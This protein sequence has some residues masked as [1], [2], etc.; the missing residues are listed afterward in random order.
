VEVLNCMDC[1]LVLLRVVDSWLLAPFGLR[2]NLR[3]ASAFRVFQLG[4]AVRAVQLHD[5][6]RELWL[7]ISAV[8]ETMWTLFWVGIMVIGVIYVCGILVSMAVLDKTQE[9]FNLERAEWD[10]NEYWGS[11][12]RSSYSLFQVVT[13][14]KWSDSLVWPLVE[15]NPELM[16]VF[17]AFFTVASLSL[18][19]S[20]VGVVVESTLA[21]ARA[22]ADREQKEKER[23]DAQVLESMKQI[24]H[25]ADT[26][27]SGQLDK[28]ELRTSFSN[29]RVR[30]RLRLLRIPFKDLEMLFQ[31]LDDES[32]GQVNADRFFRGVQRLRGQAA[33]CDLH[34]MSVDLNRRLSWCDM[35]Q[36]Q[37]NYLND[38]LAELVDTMDDMDGAVVRSDHDE[39]DPVLMSK[40]GRNKFVKSEQLRGREFKEGLM[41]KKSYDPWEEIKKQE[42]L[43]RRAERLQ[44]D[45]P[46]PTREEKRKEAERQEWAAIQEAKAEK[47]RRKEAR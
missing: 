10:F 28:D 7:V 37:V 33:A 42:F 25:D 29:F 20:I 45:E 27:K 5:T 35:H 16:V 3:F 36:S 8:G 18:M 12:L 43:Q 38:H 2:T 6:F 9:D 46:Q 39:K 23:V 14:D 4:R 26:D 13:R 32:S 40:R 31:I 19:N 21:S 24:F 17:I 22:T 47:H 44:K 30:D 11:V 15:S 41:P 34:Q 1:F